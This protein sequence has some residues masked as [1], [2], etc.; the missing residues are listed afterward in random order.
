MC[1]TI[2]I[3]NNRDLLVQVFFS[4]PKVSL[5]KTDKQYLPKAVVAGHESYHGFNRYSGG[6]LFGKTINTRADIGKGYRFTSR[7]RGKLQGIFVAVCQ[8]LPLPRFPSL[9]NR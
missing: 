1:T 4:Q 9:P 6:F 5:I 2:L 3:L 7:L 8:L